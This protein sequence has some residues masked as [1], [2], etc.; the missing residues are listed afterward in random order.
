MPCMRNVYTGECMTT[1]DHRTTCNAHGRCEGSTGECTC[2][3]GWAGNSCNVA[4]KCT[5]QGLEQMLGALE[6]DRIALEKNISE[7]RAQIEHIQASARHTSCT[8]GDMETEMRRDMRGWGSPEYNHCGQPFSWDELLS[9]FKS[10][11]RRVGQDEVFDVKFKSGGLAHL[12]NEGG[13]HTWICIKDHFCG[14]PY[15]C[16]V[17]HETREAFT[18]W[19]TARELRLL[20]V[21]GERP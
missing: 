12:S 17:Y 11:K 2:F 6:K 13:Y 4:T 18:P 9:A 15:F 21:L 1:C 16:W 3:P 7:M 19:G 8:T 20:S 10:G 5:C 14:D